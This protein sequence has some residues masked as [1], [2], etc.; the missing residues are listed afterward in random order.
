MHGLK[1]KQPPTPEQEAASAARGLKLRSLQSQFMSNHHQKMYSLLLLFPF[2]RSINQSIIC[3]SSFLVSSYTQ[4][5]IQLSAKLLVINPEAYTAWNYRKLAVL[6]NLSRIDDSDP[7]LVN[8]ILEEELE[9]VSGNLLIDCCVRLDGLLH[10]SIHVNFARSLIQVEGKMPSPL[11]L[12][13]IESG[14]WVKGIPP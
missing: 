11:G 2:S 6:D 14:S 13:I 8:S 12:G 10:I 9:F 4:E 5:A 7:I 1:R 3:W